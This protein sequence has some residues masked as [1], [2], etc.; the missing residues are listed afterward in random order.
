MLINN[1]QANIVTKLAVTMFAAA[2]GGFK[3]YLDNLAVSKA[4]NMEAIAVALSSE[5]G[6]TAMYSGTTAQ[7]V[8]TMSKN[9]SLDVLDA[10]IRQV[11]EDFLTAQIDAGVNL[12]KLFSDAIAY[13]STDTNFALA[14]STID[15]KVAVANSFTSG[16]GKDVYNLDILQSELANVTATT[17]ISAYVTKYLTVAQD[18]IF[19]DASNNLFVA[20]LSADKSTLQSGD[21]INGGAGVDTLTATLVDT[22][23]AITP[24]TSSVE[25]LQVRSQSASGTADGDNEVLEGQNTIDAQN[26]R[27]TEQFWSVDSRADLT[28][29]DVRHDSNLTTIG[30]RNA[31]AG[32]VDYSVYFNSQNIKAPAGTTSGSQLFIE[33]LDLNSMRDGT[34][35]LTNNPYS[36][37]K[38]TVGGTEVV[39]AGPTAFT[40]TYADMVTALNNALDQLG[41]PN[42]R[43]AEG[44]SFTAINSSNGQSYTGTKV[45]LTNSGAE[46][47]E[48]KGWVTPDGSLPPATNI[49]TVISDTPASTTPALT[50]TNIEL[51]NVGQASMSGDMLVGNMST[52]NSGSKGIE[53]FNVVVDRSSWIKTLATTN[54]GL[55]VVNVQNKGA[56]GNLRIDNN[57]LTDG[58]Y[59]LTDVRVVDASKM[60]GNVTLSAVLNDDVTAKFMNLKD[61]AANPAADNSDIAYRNVVDTFFSYDMGA[62]NDNLLLDI[63]SANLAKAGTTT[64]EDFVLDI[65]GNAGN[66]TIELRIVDEGTQTLS[67]STGVWYTNHKA[68]AN[69]TVNGGEGNNTIKT[70]G[71]GDVKITTGSGNDTIYSDN[72]GSQ[73][74]AST[75]NGGKATWVVNAANTLVTNLQTQNADLNL[76][77]G[78]QTSTFLVNGKLTVTLA[79]SASAG[80]G[81]N[82]GYNVTVDIP[83]GANYTVTALHVNQAI[84]AAINND[85]VLSKLMVA[86]DGPSQT[87]V[88]RSLID[89][90]FAANDLLINLTSAAVDN[91]AN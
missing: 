69:I 51:D 25:I 39:I 59:G 64:R 28:I 44:D 17:D 19:G 84:K 6:F 41:Y 21:Y 2:P 77:A 56:N 75:F 85:A 49:H 7:K 26:M 38:I 76:A 60:T 88:I 13:M 33:L 73:A 11:A 91:A 74:A 1:E 61:T 54:N 37:V 83:T 10:G 20:N 32:D 67:A 47:L 53:Q 90:A 71:A 8:A 23:F 30:F 15:K 22:P 66:D 57:N 72:A 4:Y 50:Q 9:L 36:G 86:E 16:Y 12:G 89:G 70:T 45:V 82:V 55:E 80:A 46:K 3:G 27:G 31:D 58:N 43:A 87:L 65:N 34:G 24:E 68:N 52:G 5:P 14:A 62:G 18:V 35:P 40:T 48:A 29:E 81:A 63:S 79:E 42:I 78:V